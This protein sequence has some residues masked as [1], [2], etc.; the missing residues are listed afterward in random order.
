[1][2]LMSVGEEKLIAENEPELRKLKVLFG[3]YAFFV[4]ASIIMP[5]Y[6]GVHIGYDITCAR[7]SILLFLVYVAFNPKVMTHFIQ[8]MLR[9]EIFLPFCL[10]LFVAGY[11]MVLRTDVNAF[12][13]VFL[14]I[15][16]LFMMVYGIRYVIGYRRAIK[17]VT[18]CAYF[19]GIYGLVEFLYGKSIFLKFLATVPTAVSNEYRSGQYRIMGPCGHSL[20]YG[21]VLLLFIAFACIDL[22]KNEMYL[23]KRPFLLA[24]LYI[25]VFLTG[26]RSTLGI[27]LL[28]LL[29]ILLFS[30]RTNFKKSLFYLLIAIV[31]FVGLLLLIYNTGLGQ[32]IMGQIASVIDQIFDTNFASKYGV[33]TERLSASSAYREVLPKIF[34]LDWLNPLVGRGR[35]F[36]GAEID[37]VFIHSVDNYYVVQYIKYAYP[38]LFCYV[39]FMIVLF[40]VLIRKLLQKGNRMSAVT[41]MVLI[42]CS[43][44]FLNLWWVDALQTLKYVY[45]VIA[46][47]YAMYLEE[48]DEI[49]KGEGYFCK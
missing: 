8:T 30:N 39:L 12:F 21:M 11:T 41:K 13:L 48:K 3:L 42:A 32:Y 34:T 35:G 45:I 23:F 25:N 46:I 19:L 28:E 29:L 16:A 36:G 17:W 18:G 9:C 1:M 49:P 2:R 40:W 47:F 27:A 10:Y 26:S 7:F 44:Y 14:E 37:G 5:Q 31:G 24:L 20:G 6:F 22:E 15:F 33:E 43:L 38:G 4:P